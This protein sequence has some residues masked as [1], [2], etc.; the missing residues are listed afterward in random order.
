KGPDAEAG[1]QAIDLRSVD[2]AVG[3]RRDRAEL[4]V[5]LARARNQSFGDGFSLGRR[6]LDR[7]RAD[8]SQLT[9]DLIGKHLLQA[10]AEQGRGVTAVRPGDD[11]AARS[12]RAFGPPVA[13]GAA[14]G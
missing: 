5:S 10:Q 3:L 4:D 14:V 13:G 8:G 12:C 1:V 9:R 7:L 6:L 2:G 11:V